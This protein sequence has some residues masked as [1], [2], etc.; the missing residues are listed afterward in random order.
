[1]IYMMKQGIL[2]IMFLLIN[3]GVWAQRD[4]RKGYVITNEQ[5][6]IYGWIDYRGDIRNSK[7]CSFKKIETGQVVDYFPADIA[8]Y[9]FIDGKYYISKNIGSIGVPKNIFLEY[10]VNGLAKFYYYRDD[11]TSE[12]YYLENEDHF[13]ELKIDEKEVVVDG[14]TQV[15][16]VKSYIGMLKA[17]LNVWEMSDE[18][19]K[20]KLDHES[21]INI[22][23]DYHK[24]VCTDG[25]ECI[26]YEKK[27]P[28]MIVRVGLMLGGD[29]SMLKLMQHNEQKYDLDPSLNFSCGVNLNLSIPQ[30]NEKLFLQIQALYTKYYFFDALQTSTKATDIHIRSN[31]LQLGLGIKYEYPKG[32]WRPTMMAGAAAIYL[33]DGSIEEI[34]DN[35]YKTEIRPLSK[36]DDFSAKF[37]V[38]FE[39]APGVHYYLSKNRIFFIQLQ[40]IHCFG[41]EDVNYPV[42]VVRS[43]G[44]LSG[45]YF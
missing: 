13:I 23:K 25:S 30:F 16:M 40:Y 18:I 24:Y 43:F 26:V 39:V 1:M 11:T 36:T 2:I 32:K 4:Y 17:T 3:A 10:L 22:G 31:V 27:K 45:I 38:G 9:R 35:Y 34:S 29:L 44:L 20:A 19:D 7:I 15:K 41:H 6:T 37:M 21:L 33:P 8:A 5:D 42:N 28:A 14:K 12:H